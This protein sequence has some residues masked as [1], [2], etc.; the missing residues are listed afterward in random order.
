MCHHPRLA[1]LL[2][3]ICLSLAAQ[4]PSNGAKAPGAAAATPAAW[5]SAVTMAA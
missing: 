4:A 2:P 3:L 5:E 1:A